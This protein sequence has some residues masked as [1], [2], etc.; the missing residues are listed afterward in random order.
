MNALIVKESHP[1]EECPTRQVTCFMCEGT[2]HYPARCRIYPMI[3]RTIQQKKE[4]MKGALMEILEEPVMKDEVEDT[5][6]EYPIKPCTKSCYS[7][8]EEGHISQNC[9]KGDL[10]AFPTVEVEYDRQGIE[11]PIGMEKSRK[12]NRLDPRNNPISTKKDLSHITCFR[13]KNSGH[14]HNDCPKGKMRTPGGYIITRKPRDLSEVICFRCDEA[15]HVAREC[16]KEKET[17]DK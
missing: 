8:G 5:P 9:L 10:V 1:E 15:G 11:A 16:P 2:T 13:C 12:R 4:A 3:Q 7:C 6:E 14:Y 17:C